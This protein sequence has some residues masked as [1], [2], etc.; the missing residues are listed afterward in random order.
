VKS[1]HQQIADIA[2]PLFSADAAH[3]VT[4]AMVAMIDGQVVYEGYGTEPANAFADER[5]IT[6]NSTLLSW[7]VAKSITHA[8]VGI[9][10]A[11]GLIATDTPAAVDGW[12]GSTKQG[13]TLR[14]L[15]AMRSGLAFVE[16]YDD[17]NGSDCLAMLFGE[18]A[19]DMAAYA[20]ARPLIAPPGQVWNYSSG[21]TNIICRI[22]GD[23]VHAAGGSIEQFLHERLFIPAGMTSAQPRLD[24]AGTFIGSS[25]VY[26]TATDFARFGELYR[27]GGM[28]DSGRVIAA[29]WAADAT[30]FSAA[31][32]ENGL[33]YG[34]H[35]W[36]FPQHPG[37]LACVG[38]EGQYVIVVPDR[39][40]VLVHLGKVPFESR[41]LLLN[42]L[43]R[44]IQVCPV[45]PAGVG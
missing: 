2:S 18:G 26:A 40:L 15:L 33:Q 3:G 35:W 7:S 19:D 29:E 20:A 28:A 23:A 13:I 32:P 43:D 37:S 21:T 41:S 22:L 16:E 17:S 11:D 5:A 27:R 30:V 25:Y 12:Q 42:E 38:Y 1:A 8:A 14:H 24:P 39:R 4:L 45:R 34:Q 6:A 36:M 10:V 31:D 44:I 9:A